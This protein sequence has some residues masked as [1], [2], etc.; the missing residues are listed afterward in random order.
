MSNSTDKIDIVITWVDGNDPEWRASKAEWEKKIKGI[1]D[2][3]NGDLRYRDWENLQY[4]FRG[5]ETFMPWVNKVHFVTWGHL[6]SW[7]NTDCPKL[8]V[9][10]H[11]D[12]IPEKYLPT[13]NSNTLDLNFHR[14]PGIADKFLYFNDDMFVIQKSEPEDFFLNGL[15]RDIAVLSPAP[16]FRDV[17]CNIEINNLGIINDYFTLDDVKKNRKKWYTLKYGKFLPRT[18]I[19]SKFKSIIGI[20]EP[21]VPFPHLKSTLEELWEKEYDELDKTCSN[22]FRTKED[23]N[24]WLFRHWQIMSGKFEPRRWDFGLYTRASD[25]EYISGLLKNPGKTHLICVNDSTLVTDYERSKK[26]INKAFDELLPNKSMFE[27]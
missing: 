3:M 8:N 12:Y 14:I 17:I 6:P 19:F 22:K 5:I 1:D 20:F 11:T 16:V 7:L 26:L 4:L 27:K 10:N 24:E 23:V 13:F 9:V 15:P 25:P 18:I 21:H 2:S